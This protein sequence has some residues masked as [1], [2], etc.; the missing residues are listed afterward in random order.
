M[1]P[2]EAADVYRHMDKIARLR[3]DD[4]RAIHLK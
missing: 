1:I 2:S 4:M 3:L